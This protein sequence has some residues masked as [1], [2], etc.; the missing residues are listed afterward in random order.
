MEEVRKSTFLTRIKEQE[1]EMALPEDNFVAEEM[2]S[3]VATLAI[4]LGKANHFNTALINE[5]Q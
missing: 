3:E 2:H 5:L 1:R 4:L